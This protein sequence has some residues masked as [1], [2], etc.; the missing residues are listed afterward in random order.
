MLH[1][2][3]NHDELCWNHFCILSECFIDCSEEINS[4]VPPHTGFQ[5]YQWS[6]GHSDGWTFPPLLAFSSARWPP[7]LPLLPTH[8]SFVKCRADFISLHIWELL[9]TVLL[10]WNL[11]SITSNPFK[12]SFPEWILKTFLMWNF[13]EKPSIVLFCA[14][15]IW[16]KQVNAT[17]WILIS[18]THLNFG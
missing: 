5:S 13:V 10:S 14:R 9:A 16:W 1:L 8:P 3:P 7:P 12:K 4:F 18:F 2:V 15:G 6:A 11:F 17:L